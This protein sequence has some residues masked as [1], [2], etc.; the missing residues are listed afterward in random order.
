VKDSYRI[1]NGQSSGNGGFIHGLEF[2]SLA[3][4]R[5]EWAIWKDLLDSGEFDD[6][7]ANLRKRS[8]LIGGI[9]NGYHL[10]LTGVVI[11]NAWI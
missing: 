3:R 4:V 2:L 9:L 7:R 1:H 5:E 11:T 8:E 10:H 6:T